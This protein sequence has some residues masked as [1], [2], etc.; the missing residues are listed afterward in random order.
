MNIYEFRKCHLTSEKSMY[1]DEKCQRE[2]E[3]NIICS[4][5]EIDADAKRDMKN[6]KRWKD[7]CYSEKFRCIFI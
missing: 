6:E 4:N 3:C 5:A 7:E 2:N 1:L